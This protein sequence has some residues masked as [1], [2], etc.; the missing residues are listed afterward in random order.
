M[1]VRVWAAVGDAFGWQIQE[2]WAMSRLV[3]E[4]AKVA[5]LGDQPFIFNPGM[6]GTIHVSPTE[7]LEAITCC[8]RMLTE[9][10]RSE[11]ATRSDAHFALQWEGWFVLYIYKCMN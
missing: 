10:L 5:F 1:S 8:I 3:Q 7:S 4:T 11:E 2:G 6:P 9:S